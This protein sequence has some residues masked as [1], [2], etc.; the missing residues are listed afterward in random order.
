MS[1]R[2]GTVASGPTRRADEVGARR[3]GK[4]PPE[5]A[6]ERANHQAMAGPRYTPDELRDLLG[7]RYEFSGEQ[8]DV[9]TAPAQL[10]LLVV[11]GAGSGKTELM[12]LRVMWLIANQY[13]RPDQV[14]GLTFTRKAAGELSHRIRHYLGRTLRP[15]GDDAQLSGE[16]TVATYHSFAGRIVREHGLRSGFEPST[17]LLTE[18]SCWQIADA[19]VRQYDSPAMRAFPLS[20]ESATAAVLAL[21]GDL[22]EHLVDPAQI[23]AVAAWLE[24]EVVTRSRPRVY[25]EVQKSLDRQRA[26]LAL[27]PLLRAYAEGKRGLDGMD[28]GDQLRHAAVVAR[29]HPEVGEAERDRFRVVLLDEYQDTSQAQ[30]ELLRSLFGHGHPVT[31]VGDPCQS[32]YGWRGASAGTLERFPSIFRREDGAPATVAS[33]SLSWRNAPQILA[34]ANRLSAPLRG[35]ELPVKPLAPDPGY[36][37]TSDEPL[38]CCALLDTYLCEA[39]WLAGHIR[40]AWDSAGDAARPT[41]AVLVRTRKQIPPIEAALRRLG[42]PVEV[43]G[44]GGLLDTPEVRDVVCTLQLLSDPTAGAALLRLLTGPRWRLGPRDLVALYRRAR[45]LARARMEG[46]E[47]GESE[48][49]PEIVTDRLDD[50]VLAEAMEDLGTVERYSTQGHARLVAFRGELR[51]LRRRLDQSLPDLV[52]DIAHTIGLEVEVAVRE[53]TAGAGLA[54]AHL[55]AIGD[56]AARF[57]EEAEGGT[58]SA[59]LAYLAAAET[60]ERGLPPGDVEVVEGAVQIL[61]VHAAKGLEWDVVAVAGLAKDAFPDPPKSSDHWLRGMGVLPFPLRGDR[62]SLPELDLTKASDGKCVRDAHDTFGERWREHHE[63]EERRLAYVAVTRPRRLLLAAG[64]WWGEGLTK[65]RGPS[66]FLE[67]VSGACGA[68]AGL[69]EVWAAEPAADAQNPTLAEEVSAA[70]PF[71]PLGD[72]RPAT[73]EAAALVRSAARELGAQPKGRPVR[74]ADQTE[75]LDQKQRWAIEAEL[76][77]AERARR[78]AA[79]VIEVALPAH[80]SVSQLVALRRDP[81]RLAR[82]LRRPL[83]EAPDPYARRGTAF[84]LWLERRFGAGELL[85]LDEL[86]GSGDAGAAPDSELEEL[87]KAFL[88]SVWA[89]R[90]P[91][92]VEVPFATVVSGVVVRGRMD[93]VFGVPGRPDCYDVIDWKTGHQPTGADATAAAVQLAAYRLAWAELTGVPIQNVTAGF[94]YVRDGATVRPTDLLDSAALVALVSGV[95]EST[96]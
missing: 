56:V 68:G 12:A 4:A 34:V 67:E 92:Q 73:M 1:E 53:G 38:V 81:Q 35:F 87:Q 65:P 91:V 14:L 27:L 18:A 2:S 88:A 25:A 47:A 29:D 55:D 50:A 89:D 13:V 82:R 28:F 3:G 5:G 86:P 43:V 8:R 61:T 42:L 16:P 36:R 48:A 23:E 66:A 6:V 22:A 76:L 71:D 44:L 46:R 84:H 78:R 19:A 17:R 30:V 77:L 63:R 54:R 31:A 39:E 24:S 64:Y 90:V 32:I 7:L 37:S 51:D 26:R 69:V 93:A 75:G 58:L 83:P 80:L 72:R 10:P 11:A 33:L 60:E 74:M 15:L 9:I 57:A 45:A 94:H 21:S 95:P 49:E 41:V 70:W 20:P 59:F 85:D 79:E 52:A 96:G 62:S 40:R